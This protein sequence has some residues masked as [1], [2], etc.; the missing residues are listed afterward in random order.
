VDTLSETANTFGEL[1]FGVGAASKGRNTCKPI[2]VTRGI[3]SFKNGKDTANKK[4]KNILE[5]C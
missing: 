3:H 5:I 2:F 4:I 1:V